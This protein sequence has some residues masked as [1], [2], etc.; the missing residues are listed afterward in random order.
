VPEARQCLE[1]GS[2]GATLGRPAL[3]RW[4]DGIAAGALDRLDGHSPDRLARTYAS[5]V[6][7]V[8]AVRRAEVEVM[9]LN[10]AWGQRPEDAVLLQVQGMMAEYERATSIE[11]HRRGKRQAAR[12]GV[13]QVR[14]GAPY[15]S[16]SI[17]KDAGGGQAR[18]ALV[19][20]EARLGRHVLDWVG[21]D[22]L[23]SG[24]VG[25]RLTRAGEVPRTGKTV[26]DRR[27]G[28]GMG[29]HPA[30]RGVAAF[31]KTRQAPLRPRLRAQRGRPPHPRR[32][33][34]SV[35]VP[36]EDWFPLPVPAMVEPEGC[37]AVQEPWQANRRHARQ[38]QRGGR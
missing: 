23:R 2:S 12:S 32:A 17:A 33:V 11:R 35:D 16:R 6:L 29:K 22:R 18:Y 9:V 34:S 15:G 19:P 24:E 13:V 5:H 7:L 26:W 1:A 4:R 14:S 31:G 20:D 3:E 38:S 10:R 36:P 27:V 21:R 37:A 30:S 28:W 25:R 8:E